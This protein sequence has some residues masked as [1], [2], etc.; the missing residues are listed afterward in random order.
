M[1]IES[2]HPGRGPN[3]MVD[4]GRASERPGQ[5]AFSSSFPFSPQQLKILQTF[6][7]VPITSQISAA[8]LTEAAH[9]LL[10][11]SALREMHF[12]TLLPSQCVVMQEVKRVF[13]SSLARCTPISAQKSALTME[14]KNTLLFP[15][16]QTSTKR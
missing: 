9:L 6:A 3:G 11:L 2:F 8:G 15:A 16:Q 7:N 10:V 13:M 14:E 5:I 4:E 12:F 1:Q